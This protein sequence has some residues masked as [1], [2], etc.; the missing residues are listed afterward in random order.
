M[1]RRCRIGSTSV[2]HVTGDSRLCAA[3]CNPGPQIATTITAT[4]VARRTHNNLL[5]TCVGKSFVRQTKVG[6][7][8]FS[9]IAFSLLAVTSASGSIA[10]DATTFKDLATASTTITTPAF[11]TA[12]GNELLLAFISTDYPAPAPNTTVN[13][14]TGGGLT[15]VLV[16]RT[17]VQSGTSEIW[18]AFAPSPLANVTATA[19][20]SQSVSASMTVVSFAGVDPSG[21]NGAGAIGA[22]AS[23]NAGG[24]TPTA[25][26]VTTR[27]NSWVFG[28]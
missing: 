23:A 20:L 1:H 12:A 9:A 15:W 5:R 27:N 10:I 28:V 7:R 24:G 2:V 11:S 17:N 18:R 16:V 21:A 4:T 8:L 25:T 6:T 19:T 13:A 26:L 22:T 3:G 14:V